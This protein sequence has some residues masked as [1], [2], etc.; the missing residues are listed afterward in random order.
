MC[1]H[2][3]SSNTAEFPLSL[4]GLWQDNQTLSR[5]YAGTV[6]RDVADVMSDPHVDALPSRQSVDMTVSEDH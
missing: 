4:R 3:N 6:E 2:E 1:E 5:T